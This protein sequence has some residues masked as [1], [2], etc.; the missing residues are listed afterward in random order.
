MPINKY[1]LA[2]VG[3]GYVG[4]PLAYEFSKFHNVI[5]FDI[6]Q[7][8]VNDLNLGIDVTGNL[9]SRDLLSNASLEFSNLEESLEQASVYIVTVPTPVDKSK[10][11]DL[12][13]LK[14]ASETISRYL[15]KGDLVVYEST[16][17]PGCTE[18]VCIPLLEKNSGLDV[19]KDFYCGY[20]PERINPG[21]K[22]HTLTSI[23]K[24]TSGSNELAS[25]LVDDLYKKIITAG[26]YK[27]ESIKVAE[28][29]KVVEN[30]QRDLNIALMNEL[31]LI[32]RRVGIDTKEVLDAAST[33]WNFIKFEPGLVGGHCISV[34]PY[35]LTFKA[36]ELGYE[37]DVILS[38]RKVNDFLGKDIAHRVVQ[39]LSK[40][41]KEEKSKVLIIGFSFKANCSDFRNTGVFTIFQELSKFNI[42]TD[43]YDPF[44]SVEEVKQEYA[45]NILSEVPKKKYDAIILAV[46]HN[47]IVIKGLD[48]IKS[49]GKKGFIFFDVKS[50]FDK[51]ESSH[52]L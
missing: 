12:G 52:R 24:I 8:R 9:S 19:N 20:S 47:D 34:D 41:T 39:S 38:G 21:D 46:P 51:K 36:K 29:A 2:V 6:N 37:P 5:G 44:V 17:Y 48:F 45:I 40:A 11:P 30:T 25:N 42:D 28:A 16:V 49:L 14:S 26:T 7:E 43:I 50:I 23:K 35:Y 18:E 31:S 1:K 15:K 3:L 10:N 4:I 32:F 33:K 13:P 22:E 27:A